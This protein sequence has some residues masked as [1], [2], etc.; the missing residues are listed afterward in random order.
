MTLVLKRMGVAERWKPGC[1]SGSRVEAGMSLLRD[2]VIGRFASR[3][4]INDAAGHLID[5]VAAVIIQSVSKF[6]FILRHTNFSDQ[7]G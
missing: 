4:S 5:S 6:S 2:I 1:E 7:R 3:I